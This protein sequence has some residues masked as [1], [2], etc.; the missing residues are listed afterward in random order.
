MD[1]NR[2]RKNS[3]LFQ[4]AVVVV[5]CRVCERKGRKEQ[6]REAYSDGMMVHEFFFFFGLFICLFIC[7]RVNAWVPWLP[8]VK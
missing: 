8:L 4:V 5:D 6:N 1:K 2:Q 3:F 7:C